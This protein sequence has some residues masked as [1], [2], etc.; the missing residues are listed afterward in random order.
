MTEPYDYSDPPKTY[1]GV[2][3]ILSLKWSDGLDKLNWWGPDNNGY[4]YD[5]DKAGRYDAMEITRN[6]SYYDNNETTRAV[7]I[8]DVYSGKLGTVQKIIAS[9]FSYPRKTFDCHVCEREVSY[10]VDPR[11]SP[12][13]CRK[14]G[15][16]I[17]AI[18]YDEN[19][20][21]RELEEVGGRSTTEEAGP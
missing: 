17:C 14:C 5:I 11:F 12:L 6:P 18:C 1:Q 10:R 16:Q 13:S 9:S 8:S 3:L 21:D 19:S 15:E 2:Y 4:S 20:C 7:P